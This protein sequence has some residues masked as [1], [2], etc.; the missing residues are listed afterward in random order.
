MIYRASATLIRRSVHN[1]KMID[2]WAV[3]SFKF[4]SQHRCVYKMWIIKFDGLLL[5]Y[6]VIEN[7][8][9]LFY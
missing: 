2:W 7:K 4:E 8:T 9:G 3:T 1:S 6:E 5:I